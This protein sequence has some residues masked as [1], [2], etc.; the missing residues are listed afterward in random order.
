MHVA[1][2]LMWYLQGALVVGL[3]TRGNETG[4]AGDPPKT[5]RV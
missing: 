4:T 5:A 3:D 2:K 1:R